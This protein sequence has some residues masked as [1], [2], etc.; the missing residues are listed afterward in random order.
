MARAVHGALIVHDA[1]GNAVGVVQGIYDAKT[2]GVSV[3]GGANIA[4][5]ALGLSS[6]VRQPPIATNQVPSTANVPAP[7][8]VNAVPQQASKGVGHQPTTPAPKF[9]V[10]R[11]KDMPSPRPE[12]NSHHA[13]MSKWMGQHFP[14]YDANKA[15]AVLMPTANHR[16][17]TSVYNTWRAK[18]KRERGTFDWAK[19][20]EDDIRELSREMFKAAEVPSDIQEMYWKEYERMKKALK[21]H[22]PTSTREA[23]EWVRMI[24]Y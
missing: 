14:G 24:T 10:G 17:T 6:H 1:A 7:K 19:I 12:H 4:A 15:P 20:S 8:S 16:K 5:N 3:S 18:I 11:H 9:K 13:V 21:D 23:M 2:N 22:S